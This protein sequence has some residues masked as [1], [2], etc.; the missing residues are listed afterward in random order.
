MR[1]PWH[2]RD[3]Q[4]MRV[5]QEAG[6]IYDM[7]YDLLRKKMPNGDVLSLSRGRLILD[8]EGFSVGMIMRYL[9]RVEAEH[10]EVSDG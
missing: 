4:V 7:P 3:D 2:E 10:V 1:F 6:W 9:N 5:A 8:V